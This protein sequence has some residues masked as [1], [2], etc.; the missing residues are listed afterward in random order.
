MSNYLPPGC[1]QHDPRAPWNLPDYV[2]PTHHCDEC[3]EHMERV[4][5][6][7]LG[8][9]EYLCDDCL[10]EHC[11]MQGDW[12][13]QSRAA[14]MRL[15]LRGKKVTGSTDGHQS[16]GRRCMEALDIVDH[17]TR[18]MKDMPQQSRRRKLMLY[19]L[20]TYGYDERREEYTE[21]C[22]VEAAFAL[23]NLFKTFKPNTYRKP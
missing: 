15:H 23:N 11:R 18:K 8:G 16:A 19:F 17:A 20:W 13:D 14:L 1:Q 7:D 10:V 6:N 9:G 22:G 5:L 21:R 2:E 12:D 3:R 4:H